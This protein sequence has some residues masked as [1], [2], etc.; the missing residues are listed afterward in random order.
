MQIRSHHIFAIMLIVV[1][2][3]NGHAYSD[4]PA[5]KIGRA[6]ISV[7]IDQ[8]DL[9]GNDGRVL[10]AAV[11]YVAGLGGGTVRIG[12]G[13]YE[14]RNSLILHDNVRVLGVAG[15]TVLVSREGRQSLLA[16]TGGTNERQIS[17]AEPKGF[18]I[19]DGIMVQD[20]KS[21]FGFSVTQTM[22]VGKLDDNTFQIS[23]PLYHDYSVSR[24]ARATTAFPV[25]G[26]WN[27]KSVEIVGLTIDGNGKT[28]DYLTGC[29]G[30]GIFLF[31]CDDVT[32]RNCT[33]R[34]YNGDGISFQASKKVVIEDCL[35]E[36][37]F[38]VGLHPGCGT[39]APIVRGNR[40]VNN[41]GDGLFVC[42]RVKRGVFEDNDFSH[43]A[44][45][46]ISIGHKDSDNLFRNNRIISN[47]KV[48]IVFR[49][50]PVSGGA[51][52]N[53]FE[54]NKILDNGECVVVRG[55]HNGL[56]FRKNT[57]GTSK[58]SDKPAAGII[59][60]KSA[61]GLRTEA[62]EFVNVTPRRDVKK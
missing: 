18:R 36:K 24:K 52:R 3:R 48:G 59:A 62:N 29:R 46:G 2:L 49:S 15:K 34:N 39:V 17:I 51:H 16:S 47:A 20:D 41:I 11:D 10:Q 1:A 5:A 58:P 37:N 61:E 54:L 8:G 27:V 4:E 30:G 38:G 33:V 42:W 21:K 7:G 28:V 44:R 56:V 13:R 26:L 19:G 23:R 60:D 40:C 14:M 6:E 9:R 57:I 22:I 25:L 35:C 50:Q 53:V 12:P 31:E 43:N 45:N 32:I 55:H